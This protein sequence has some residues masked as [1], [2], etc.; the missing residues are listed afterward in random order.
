MG[1]PPQTT[2]RE[3][4][5]MK[6]LRMMAC[7]FCVGALALAARRAVTLLAQECDNICSGV[8][9]ASYSNL[10][11]SCGYNNWELRPR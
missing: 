3:V 6:R 7:I 1:E 8:S 10:S 4:M 9:D 5:T 2:R 11:A